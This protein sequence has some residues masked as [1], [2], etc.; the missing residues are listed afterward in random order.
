MNTIRRARLI[1]RAAAVLA[2]LTGSLLAISTAAPAA[3]VT[4]GAIQACLTWRTW[5]R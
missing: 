2:G 4:G 5:T 1:R 3:L